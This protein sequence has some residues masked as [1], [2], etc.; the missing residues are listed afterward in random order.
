MKLS[1]DFD[2]RYPEE[3]EIYCKIVGITR[4]ENIA[5]AIR[6]L[7]FTV[8]MEEIEGDDVDI[9]VYR[10]EELVLVIEVL[11]WKESVY[12]DFN[13]VKSIIQNFSDSKY[14]NSKKLLVYSFDTNIKNQIKF[15]KDFDIDF[16]EIGF[17]TQPV[18][19][20]K[21]YSFLGRASG[22]RPDNS[23]T[24]Q[25]EKDKIIAYLRNIGLI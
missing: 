12:M 19:Y 18:D 2:R 21:Y 9:W 24:K 7:N 10:G 11:N 6:S 15:F 16:L 1:E 25:I 3:R 20:Y 5:E 13:R 4:V 14:S 17:Q 8:L 22:M 23:E